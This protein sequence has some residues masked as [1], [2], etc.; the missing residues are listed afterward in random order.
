M[1]RVGK[2]ASQRDLADRD[3]D[4]A[5]RAGLE[6][7]QAWN[8]PSVSYALSFSLAIRP[9]A[10]T[11]APDHSGCLGPPLDIELLE[12]V[13]DVIFDGGGADPRAPGD[14]F[15]GMPLVDKVDNLELSVC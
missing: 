13:V 8:P 15:V 7:E 6:G 1:L 14:L 5:A 4:E 11:D 9:G 3:C 12:N 2:I 10:G